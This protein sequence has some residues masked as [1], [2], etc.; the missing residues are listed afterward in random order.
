[1]IPDIKRMLGVT[2]GFGKSLGV[3]DKWVYNEIK[4][5]GNYGEIFERNVGQNSPLKLGARAQ[6]FVDQG[7]AD[8]WRCRSADLQRGRTY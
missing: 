5:V 4:L 2:P 7:R 8:L 6:Q 3:D 1:M